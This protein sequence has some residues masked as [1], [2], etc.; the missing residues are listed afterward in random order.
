MARKRQIKGA[1]KVRRK[2]LRMPEAIQDQVKAAISRGADEVL[3]EMQKTVPVSTD[4]H[5]SREHLQQAL[6]RRISK[7]GLSARVGLLGIKAHRL[8][9]FWKFL[10][11]G[12]RKMTKR[13]FAF[14][15]WRKVRPKIRRDVR[16][17]VVRGFQVV[18]RSN[19]PD[20]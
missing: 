8:Y 17:A 7:N 6:E 12:T 19:L 15:S 18:A 11:F 20:V 10:E 16:N 14:P 2:I 3:F 5:F 4:V 9:F 1:S 13:P